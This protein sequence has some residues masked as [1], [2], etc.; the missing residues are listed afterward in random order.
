VLVRRPVPAMAAT[1]AVFAAA[2]ITMSLRVRP[3]LITPLHVASALTPADITGWSTSSGGQMTVTGGEHL[4]G[5]WVLS[6]QSLSANG[7]V[8]TGPATRACVSGSAQACYASLG[9]LHLRQLRT[10]QPASRYWTFQWYETAIFLALAL[11]LAGLC[12][13]WIRRRRLA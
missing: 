12:L 7:H 1:L 9:R 13:C 8:F 6:N 2:L 3:H 11:A 4:P 10:Y 5:A